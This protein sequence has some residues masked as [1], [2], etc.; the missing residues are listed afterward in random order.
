MFVCE[1]LLRFFV[2]APEDRGGNIFAAIDAY[3]ETMRRRKAEER[4]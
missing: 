4:S 1:Y 2:L 3:K